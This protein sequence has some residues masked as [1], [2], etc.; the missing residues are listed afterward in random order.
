MKNMTHDEHGE[1]DDYAQDD[2]QDHEEGYKGDPPW[3][4]CPECGGSPSEEH[5]EGCLFA[6]PLPRCTTCDR[7][8][9]AHSTDGACP[10]GPPA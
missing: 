8:A 9:S 7:P 5:L 2:P 4:Y 6:T 1:V 10:D 3:L